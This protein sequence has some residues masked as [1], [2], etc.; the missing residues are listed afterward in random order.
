MSS[1]PLQ[2]LW[3][4]LGFK[5]ASTPVAELNAE[6]VEQAE[7]AS[8]LVDHARAFQDL[9]VTDV[10]TPRVD[11]VGIDETATLSELV[12]LC[13]Q[14]EH[15]RLPVY[16]GG[17][18]D[19]IG[20]VHIK[21]VLKWLAPAEGEVVPART[22]PN[23][24]NWNEA[25][26]PQILREVIYAPTAMTAANLLRTMKLKRM[27]MAL[28]IDEFGG[29]D[30]L[31]TLEDLIEAVVGDIEDEYDDEE[32]D[33]IRLTD[34]GAEADG[35]VEIVDIEERLGVPLYPEDEE[36]ID[37]IGGLV[38]FLAGRVPETGEVIPYV[39]AGFDLEVLDGDARRV[40]RVRLTRRV[41]E[42]ARP[43]NDPE[44]ADD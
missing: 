27:H 15:S 24:P 17:L 12:A 37:T 33:R 26:V 32:S 8:E 34:T 42:D 39:R 25:V 4:A 41:P 43:D 14:S 38:T 40:T 19:P 28:V 30:G 10:M 5:K 31:V 20:V 22:K 9:R 29:T 11:I 13:V 1:D 7:A 6:Q 36:D 16:R 2:A 35:R 3:V 23:G 21:D 18:D 44:A